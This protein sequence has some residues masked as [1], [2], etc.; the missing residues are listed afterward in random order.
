VTAQERLGL[1]RA[2]DEREERHDALVRSGGACKAPRQ[3]KLRDR[4]ESVLNPQTLSRLTSA[5]TDGI[6]LRGLRFLS[7]GSNLALWPASTAKSWL[8]S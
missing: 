4:A 6:V 3:D 1:V 2:A 8:K 5:Y 7:R